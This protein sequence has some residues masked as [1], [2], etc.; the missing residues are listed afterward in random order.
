METTR[1]QLIAAA[2]GAVAATTIAG[3]GTNGDDL[4]A[5]PEP[6]LYLAGAV[7]HERACEELN[8]QDPIELTAGT[9]VETAT[10]LE[11]D[12]QSYS[13]ESDD[14]QRFL[15][16]EDTDTARVFYFT[17]GSAV[18]HDGVTAERD[19]IDEECD[20][21]VEYLEV[22]PADRQITI[23]LVEEPPEDDPGPGE[24]QR[25]ELLAEARVDHE[26]ACSH[27]KWDPR[28]P[29]EAGTSEEDAPSVDRTHVIWE[30]THESE[31]GFVNFDAEA[32]RHDGPF[33][34]YLAGG[35]ATVTIG[36]HLETEPVPDEVCKELD[37][38]VRVTPDAGQIQ[39]EVSGDE[40][41]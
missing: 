41:N 10:A 34:F 2:S 9:S 28:T 22:T 21:F 35:T 13:I 31:V 36:E 40:E 16:I 18:V 32:H 7:S 17:S 5:D 33:V 3:C 15:Q 6:T 1:R 26:H 11:D 12:Y 14:E 19:T 25:L 30:V 27:A 20:A 23:E 29:L 24:G 39:L 8:E 37:R 38:Y 4:S